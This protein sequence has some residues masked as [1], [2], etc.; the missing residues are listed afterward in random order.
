MFYNLYRFPT[1]PPANREFLLKAIVDSIKPDLLMACE[2]VS[3]TGANRIINSSFSNLKDSFARAEFHYSESAVADPLQQMVFYN[4]RKLIL[5]KERVLK[6]SVRDINHYTF[7]L[8]LEHLPNDSVFVEV[9]VTHLKS[10]EGPTNRALRLSMVDTFVNALAQIPH[11]HYVLFAGDFNFYQAANEPAYQ[12][13]LDK[14]NPIIMIDPIDMPGN[15]HDNAA[16]SAIHTQAT[17]TSAAGFGLG[18]ATGGM[19]DR[20]DFITISENSKNNPAFSYVEDSYAA[21]GNNGN[22][23]DKSIHDTSCTGIY[24]FSIREK[25]HNMSDHVPIIMKFKTNYSFNIA[26]TKIQNVG[27]EIDI[28]LLNG[29]IIEDNLQISIGKGL[30]FPSTILVYNI[31]GKLIN[32]TPISP[33]NKKTNIDMSAYAPGMYFLKMDHA[34]SPTLKFIKK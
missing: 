17:R 5:I 24:S 14:T 11:N 32:K 2:I 7:I 22:C 28:Q 33:Y 21:Y 13:I 9:F 31:L 25:L 3:E 4:T 19:D 8:N 23:F 34:F 6:T 29:N 26:P 12:K 15:W 30:I 10:S 20:F 1:S 18:G 27:T 16:F